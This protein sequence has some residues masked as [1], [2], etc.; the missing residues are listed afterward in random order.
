MLPR[1]KYKEKVSVLPQNASPPSFALLTVVDVM[2][3]ASIVTLLKV[4]TKNK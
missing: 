1:T 2:H 3:K 4:L